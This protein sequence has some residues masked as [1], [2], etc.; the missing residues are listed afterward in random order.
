LIIALMPC[1][2]VVNVDDRHA[3]QVF[4]ARA[5][6]QELDQIGTTFTSPSRG[7]C[8]HEIEHLHVLFERQA[9]RRGDRCAPAGRSGGIGQRAQQGSPR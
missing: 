4:Q 2:D 3:V 8:S 5:Q 1:R 7:S 9:R 6:G